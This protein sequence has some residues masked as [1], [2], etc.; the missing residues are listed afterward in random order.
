MIP[1]TTY[2]YAF[3]DLGGTKREGLRCDLPCFIMAL[4]PHTYITYLSGMSFVPTVS[5][6][7]RAL[8][9]PTSPNGPAQPHLGPLPMA[10]GHYCASA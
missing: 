1:T 6:G 2:A 8:S 4:G 9:T 5:T 7:Y 10:H 3:S